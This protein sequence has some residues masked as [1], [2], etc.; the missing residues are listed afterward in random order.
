MKITPT[1]PQSF[2]RIAN[3]AAALSLT[4]ASTLPSAIAADSGAAGQPSATGVPEV[5]GQSNNSKPVTLNVETLKSYGF[6][7]GIVGVLMDK[8]AVDNATVDAGGVVRVDEKSKARAGGVFEAHY[9]FGDV[10]KGAVDK[11][12][13]AKTQGLTNETVT[14]GTV[15]SDLAHGPSF[16]VELGESVIRSIGLGYVLSWRDL[17]FD[18][19]DGST[20][21]ST[22]GNAFNLGI[23]VLMEPDVKVLAE[24]I[25]KNAPLPAGDSIRF[26]REASFGGGILFSYSF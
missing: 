8:A 19:K 7:A 9:F 15:K 2:L 10:R 12:K 1:R 14:T 25:R 17:K 3:L 22:V 4:V 5:T 20:T 18:T 6:G 21:I 11:V 16:V 13:K 24:G 23:V 26:K